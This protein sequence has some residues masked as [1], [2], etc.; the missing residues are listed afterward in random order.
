MLALK[1]CRRPSVW[2]TS[3]I[4]TSLRPCMI[5]FSRFASTILGSRVG[6]DRRRAERQ[7]HAHAL[8]QRAIGAGQRPLGEN[9]PRPLGSASL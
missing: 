9:G 6:H 2:P 3:C 5:S 7:L 1:L 8:G 4:V